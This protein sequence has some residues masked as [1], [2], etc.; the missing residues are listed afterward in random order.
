MN[1][2]S[3]AIGLLAAYSNAVQ[4]AS[5]ADADTGANG[6]DVN[7]NLD[8]AVEVKGDHSHGDHHDSSFGQTQALVAIENAAAA[9]AA[10]QA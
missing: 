7:I 9:L 8:F 4:I 5:E 3:W 1:K 2:L 10:A 6:N